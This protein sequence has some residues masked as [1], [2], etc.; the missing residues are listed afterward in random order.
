MTTDAPERIETILIV[1]DQPQT[2]VILEAFLIAAGYAVLRA[3]SGEQALAILSESTCD[4]VLL[5]VLMPR[6][7][8]F[9]T[10]RRLRALPATATVPVVFLTAASA[11]EVLQHALAADAEDLLT[12]PINRIE[13]LMRVRS[14][15][16]LK[17][18]RDELRLGFELIRS[19]HEALQRAQ[20]SR[21]QLSRLLVHDL[22]GPVTTILARASHLVAEPALDEASRRASREVVHAGES[23]RRMVSN[24]LDIS[25]SEEGVLAPRFRPVEPGVLLEDARAAMGPV[26]AEVGRALQLSVGPLPAV[27]ADPELLH[28]VIENLLDNALRSTPVGGCVRVEAVETAGGEVE[29]RVLDEGGSLDEATSVFESQA[30][31]TPEAQG[32]FAGHGL[33]LVFCRLALEAHGGRIWAEPRAPSGRAFCFRLPARTAGAAGAHR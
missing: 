8:G 29:V 15:L 23:L 4:L 31:A 22:Q 27:R 14:L 30:R 17:R 24:L 5:D 12:K 1:D 33:A 13:L 20:R 10:L 21:E 28:R 2:L 3:E 26:F 18:L 9:E 32:A 19:Q 6:M 25:R 11:G 16:R 7:D